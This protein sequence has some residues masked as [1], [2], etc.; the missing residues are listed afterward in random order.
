M[1]RGAEITIICPRQYKQDGSPENRGTHREA[2]A[3][4]VQEALVERQ[5]LC[6]PHQ[7][8][9]QRYAEKSLSGREDDEGSRKSRL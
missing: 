2:E 9:V 1:K 8:E 5:Q 7:A 4:T 3:D 6:L